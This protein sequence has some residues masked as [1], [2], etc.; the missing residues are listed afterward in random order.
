MTQNSEILRNAIQSSISV[1][2]QM[3]ANQGDTI[4][5]IASVVADSLKNGGTL[6]L[7]GNGG[8]ADLCNHVAAEF[9]GRFLK[10]RRP[11]PAV[12]LCGNPSLLTAIA[13]DYGYEDVF[14]RQVAALVKS[15]DVLCGISTSGN[16][17]NVIAAMKAAWCKSA[18]V[19]GMT[20]EGGGEIGDHA[21]LILRVPSRST[22]HVQEMHLLAWHV[23]AELVERELCG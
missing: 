19:F 9:V 1:A 16:S 6:Y 18:G 23:I 8:S 3:L 13:N 2:G 12:S 17:A 20:G 14:S 21:N 5:Q 4:L 10:D 11:L 15:G 22:P 7:C